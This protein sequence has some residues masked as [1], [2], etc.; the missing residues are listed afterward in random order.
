MDT[1]WHSLCSTDSDHEI[2]CVWLMCSLQGPAV[3]MKLDLTYSSY[4]NK[5]FKNFKI[6]SHKHERYISILHYCM[7]YIL[8]VFFFFSFLIILFSYKALCKLILIEV[9]ALN[10]K[11]VCTSQAY[12]IWLCFWVCWLILCNQYK[13]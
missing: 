3:N 9:N 7:Y 1:D 8:F 11:T 6:L 2:F 4:Y 10:G 12:F 5:L 13:S